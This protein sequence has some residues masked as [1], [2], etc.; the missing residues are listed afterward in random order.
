MWEV[1]VGRLR[2]VGFTAVWAALTGLGKFNTIHTQAFSLGFN[3]AGF[4]P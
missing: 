1:K 4:Q 2:L 3:I